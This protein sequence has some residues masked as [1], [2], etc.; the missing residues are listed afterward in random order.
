MA[1]ISIASWKKKRRRAWH[2]ARVISLQSSF[3]TDRWTVIET[4][5]QPGIHENEDWVA[6]HGHDGFVWRHLQNRFFLK[7]N[8]R[9]SAVLFKAKGLEVPN[10]NTKKKKKNTETKTQTTGTKLVLDTGKGRGKKMKANTQDRAPRSLATYWQH[11]FVPSNLSLLHIS[12]TK[13]LEVSISGARGSRGEEHTQ[14]SIG[15]PYRR[16]QQ[17]QGRPVRPINSVGGSFKPINPIDGLIQVLESI[18]GARPL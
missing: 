8:G 17:S 15:E 16:A 7:V 3:L 4:F 13:P 9:C 11:Q 6:V 12:L 5:Q 2:F 14:Y 1:L 18:G 10:M